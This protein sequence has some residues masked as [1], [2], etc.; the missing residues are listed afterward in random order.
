MTS[1]NNLLFDIDYLINSSFFMEYLNN[2]NNNIGTHLYHYTK[3]EGFYSILESSKIWA[4]D[5]RSLNDSEEIYHAYKLLNLIFDDEDL[6]KQLAPEIQSI[7]P[8]LKATFKNWVGE[9]PT[10]FENIFITSFSIKE[11]D[12][13]QW[14]AY[15]DKGGYCIG[16]PLSIF[17]ESINLYDKTKIP[18]IAH[19]ILFAPCIYDDTLKVKLISQVLHQ[20]YNKNKGCEASYFPQ[21]FYK[22]FK[23]FSSLFK[24]SAFSSEMEYR[25][26]IELT[27]AVG[28]NQ[29]EVLKFIKYRISKNKMATYIE[30]PLDFSSLPQVPDKKNY[31]DIRISNNLFDEK[32][33]NN[34]TN[35][36]LS[37]KY[38][39]SLV[40]R[41]SNNPYIFN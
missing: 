7:V 34:I 1:H 25:I 41:K 12:L 40:V 18:G 19:K 35:F 24:H 22:A 26:I 39:N 6:K 31:L 16:L 32:N 5:F 38:G 20:C 21:I 4:T 8:E 29:D 27:P 37:K 2:V 33:K 30:V 15:C 23:I 13:N 17:T 9:K 36:L 3:P 28:I 10:Q 14:R 11:D